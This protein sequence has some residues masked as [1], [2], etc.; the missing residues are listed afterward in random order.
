MITFVAR[1]TDEIWEVLEEAGTGDYLDWLYEDGVGHVLD[2]EMPTS[3]EE[4]FR[5]ALSD[6]PLVE[7]VTVFCKAYIV[8]DTS[9]TP[10]GKEYD[11]HW[12]YDTFVYHIP[13]DAA[14][15]NAEA[16][17]ELVVSRRGFCPNPG[18]QRLKGLSL[19]AIKYGL[20]DRCADYR[21][22]TELN[23][24]KDPL[25]PLRKQAARE[26]WRWADYY[27]H[28]RRKVEIAKAATEDE[29][30][31]LISKYGKEADKSLAC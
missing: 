4:C 12:E 3:D 22:Q 9:D 13:Q 5:Q 19:Y 15:E 16:W 25:Y 8:D 17:C 29:L 30:R 24:G 6:M 28:E 31:E 23:T 20:C 11:Y 10:D 7:G 18:C 21:F 2:W 26:A 27:Q 1:Y 14:R